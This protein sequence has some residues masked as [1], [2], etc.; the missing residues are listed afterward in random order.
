MKN[1][2]RITFFL[3]LIYVIF[4][5]MNALEG[6]FQ[7]LNPMSLLRNQMH[8]FVQRVR[9]VHVWLDWLFYFTNL[10]FLLILNYFVRKK[11]MGKGYHFLIVILG[12]FPVAA[13]FLWFIIWRKL[14]RAVF[15]YSEKNFIRSDRK[16]ICLWVLIILRAVIPVIY[17]LL[18]NYAQSPEFISWLIHLKYYESFF[19]SLYS[20]IFSIIG[21][22]YFIE[23]R[24]IIRDLKPELVG[25]RE[26]ELLDDRIVSSDI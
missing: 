9:S 20:L 14:N 22:L 7:V 1:L 4:I 6:F 5:A 2:R 11:G 24:K 13:Y 8:L 12:F 18:V 23:F 10:S 3:I 21:L 25:V 19:G 26:N 17:Y 16:I 15:S